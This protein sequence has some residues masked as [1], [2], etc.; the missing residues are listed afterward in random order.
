V[1]VNR[2]AA[3]L[4]VED[5]EVDVVAENPSELFAQ[6]ASVFERHRWIGAAASVADTLR[7]R[8]RLA[9]TCLGHGVAIPHGRI[10]GLKRA[11]AA[12][13]RVRK[14]LAFGGPDDEPV[15]LFIFLFVPEL[16]NQSDLE[17][18]AEIAE[19]LSDKATRERL[20]HEGDAGSV[21]AMIA[22][23]THERSA[24]TRP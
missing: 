12:V 15:T 11:V 23:W 4:D 18:L 21:F 14:P 22:G 5:V 8:E 7:E 13:L 20:K 17:I 24:S 3:V 16:A 9:S 2:L 6:A 10:K 19:M 1:A